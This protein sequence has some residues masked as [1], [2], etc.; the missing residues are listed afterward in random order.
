L[1]RARVFNCSRIQL[2]DTNI[3]IEK[4]SKVNFKPSKQSPRARNS[5]ILCVKTQSKLSDQRLSLAIDNPNMSRRKSKVVTSSKN[6]PFGNLEL[7]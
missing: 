3:K 1:G 4:I 7:L 2:L 5:S 6:N